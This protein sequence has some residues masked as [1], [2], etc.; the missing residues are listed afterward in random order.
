MAL[1]QRFA[2]WVFHALYTLSEIIIVFKSLL[3]LHGAELEAD[4]NDFGLGVGKL[5]VHLAVAFTTLRHSDTVG[6][7]EDE[8]LVDVLMESAKRVMRWCSHVGVQ[9]VTL[10]DRHGTRA[11]VLLSNYLV[12]ALI[13]DSWYSG[14]LKSRFHELE[15][16]CGL[17][18]LDVAETEDSSNI[19]P[20]I[21]S[22]SRKLSQAT[23]RGYLTP[24]PSNHSTATSVV[25]GSDSAEE[26]LSFTYSRAESVHA[27]DDTGSDNSDAEHISSSIGPSS[28]RRRKSSVSKASK[29]M[30]IT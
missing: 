1:L 27:C 6:E 9:T 15:E 19:T 28:L 8:D 18:S 14:I 30:C 24:P 3:P 29:G 16:S 26:L 12:Y 5:P 17:P 11:S 21:S 10:Y 13:W 23:S 20:L 2:L 4:E 25:D 22:P 7:D